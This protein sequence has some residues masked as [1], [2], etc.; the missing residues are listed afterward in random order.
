MLSSSEISKFWL[1]AIKKKQLSDSNNYW[2]MNCRQTS[3]VYIWKCVFKKIKPFSSNETENSSF[4]KMIHRFFSIGIHTYFRIQVLSNEQREK[5]TYVPT[6]QHR[7]KTCFN[8]TCTSDGINCP[9]YI[10]NVVFFFDGQPH[11]WDN[12]T[13]RVGPWQSTNFDDFESFKI[14]NSVCLFNLRCMENFAILCVA[15]RAPNGFV[16]LKLSLRSY[17]E[18]NCA[19]QTWFLF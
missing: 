7:L 6:C 11:K 16:L 12:S 8:F 15:L 5:I 19:S 4:K 13:S 9:M 1:L 17:L 3:I 2:T 18:T 14:L 10:C